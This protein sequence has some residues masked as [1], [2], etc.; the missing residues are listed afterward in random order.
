[1]Q[2]VY[3][4]HPAIG[5]ARLGNS[6]EFYLAPET[7][8]GLPIAC[9]PDGTVDGPEHPVTQFKDDRP[10]PGKDR[11]AGHFGFCGHNDP[12]AFRNIR[13]QRLEAR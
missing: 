10:H 11:T 5:I 3:K 2:P 13:I 6:D 12:V 8:G 7:T 1:M 9:K 4:I